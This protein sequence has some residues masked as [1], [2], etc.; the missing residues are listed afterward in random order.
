M[1]SN[2]TVPHTHAAD[3]ADAL[4]FVNT[5]ALIH[6]EPRDDLTTAAEA[7]AW[8]E[9]RG[10]V[11]PE[12]VKTA[13]GPAALRRVRRVRA[14]LRELA[15]AGHT[16]RT[17]DAAALSELNRVLGAREIL[18][19]VPTADGLRLDHRHGRHPL[20]EALG[21]LVEPMVREIG[22][23]RAARLRPCANDACRWLFYDAS[24]QRRRRWCDM[25]SCGNRAKAAR[26]R[27]R[28]RTGPAPV[29]RS[30]S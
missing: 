2:M 14:A 26:H 8:L 5:L 11:H 25:A 6:G 3:L 29:G 7:L 16:G 24:R 9:A 12:A 28:R 13:T 10:L 17:P 15:E 20:E 21:R 1:V 27:A 23:G 22:E 30:S 18:A 4:A 19:L